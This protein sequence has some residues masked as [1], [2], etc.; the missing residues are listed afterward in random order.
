MKLRMAMVTAMA[1]TLTQAIAFF[2][3]AASQTTRSTAQPRQFQVNAKTITTLP[4]GEMY[5]L[6]LTKRGVRYDF[7]PGAGQID[8]SRVVVRTAK[9][10]VTIAN[11]LTD[12][13]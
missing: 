1:I 5:V 13:F 6:D 4:N 12:N 7:D 9:G 2:S 8:L 11:F 3:P 10:E